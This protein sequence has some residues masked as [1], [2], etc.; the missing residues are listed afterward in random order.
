MLLVQ[1]HCKSLTL[2][3]EHGEGRRSDHVGVSEHVLLARWELLRPVDDGGFEESAA[4]QL[5]ERHQVPHHAQTG[6]AQS[7]TAESAL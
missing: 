1:N 5:E 3:P 4:A 6:N 7:E 2:D